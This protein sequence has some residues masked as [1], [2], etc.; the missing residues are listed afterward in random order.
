MF[1]WEVL[2]IIFFYCSF[3]LLQYEILFHKYAL[4][5]H[6]LSDY[7]KILHHSGNLII[8]SSICEFSQ[9]WFNH[10]LQERFSNYY[11]WSHNYDPYP[12][13][14]TL[15]FTITEILII[16]LPH[17]DWY[18]SLFDNLAF[19]PLIPSSL[20]HLPSS[21]PNFYFYTSPLPHLSVYS[22]V[23]HLQELA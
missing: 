9:I 21:C 18:H 19:S 8:Y 11:L 23:F 10:S 17:T 4:V 2:V 20:W 1:Q 12:L 22:I 14:M 6:K 15:H 5:C 13:T 16:S 3:M 7:Y